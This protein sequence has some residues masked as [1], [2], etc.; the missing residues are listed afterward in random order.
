MGGIKLKQEEEILQGTI[1]TGDRR[2]LCDRV[3]PLSERGIKAH[4]RKVCSVWRSLL[5][6]GHG[7]KRVSSRSWEGWKCNR[8][9]HRTANRW[10]RSRRLPLFDLKCWNSYLFTIWGVKP[11]HTTPGVSARRENLH[12]GACC[13]KVSWSAPNTVEQ[14]Y[15]FLRC[16]EGANCRA[17]FLSF[18]EKWNGSCNRQRTKRKG[19]APST[20]DS[21]P[22]QKQ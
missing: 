15:V 4:P 17:P 22:D 19:M 3:A 13:K 2:S 14:T 16:I 12:T 9:T 21:G 11:K 1:V 18:H 5:R 20:A 7:L 6:W 8:Q 10:N